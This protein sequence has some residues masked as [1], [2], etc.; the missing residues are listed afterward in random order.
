MGFFLIFA[1]YEMKIG[2]LKVFINNEKLSLI[3]K[4]EFKLNMKI[5]SEA[6]VANEL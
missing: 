2:I 3:D 4:S 1:N 5:E 6:F